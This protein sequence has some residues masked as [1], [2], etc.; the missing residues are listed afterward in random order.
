MTLL[1]T[2][3]LSQQMMPLANIALSAAACAQGLSLFSACYFV[4]QAV[5]REREWLRHMPIDEEVAALEK[6]EELKREK[7]LFATKWGRMPF[8]MRVRCS[9]AIA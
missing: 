4:E 8:A 1:S 3:Q 7:Y 2:D 6:R 9:V 5:D